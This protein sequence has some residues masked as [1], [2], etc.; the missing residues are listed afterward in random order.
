MEYK[1]Y[2]RT[3]GILRILSFKIIE[4][5]YIGL[6]SSVKQILK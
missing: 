1:K 6:S 3:D 5:A 4:W 2:R